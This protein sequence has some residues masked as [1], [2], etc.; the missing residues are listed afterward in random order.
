MG[1]NDDAEIA[2][3]ALTEVS[4]ITSLK[5]FVGSK[6]LEEVSMQY[7]CMAAAI[8]HTFGQRLTLECVADTR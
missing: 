8:R 6:G 5:Q 2:V 7:T 4:Q 3:S 1:A